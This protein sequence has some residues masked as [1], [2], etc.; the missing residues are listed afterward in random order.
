V[1]WTLEH[2]HVLAGTPWWASI[3]IAAVVFRIVQFYP[4]VL[5]ADNGARMAAITPYTKPIQ[6]KMKAAMA[7]GDKNLAAQTQQE[8]QRIYKKSGIKIWK[9]FTPLLGGLIGFGSW[10]ILRGMSD[11]PVPGLETG[12]LLWFQN[13]AIPDPLFLLPLATSVIMHFVFKVSFSSLSAN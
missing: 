13:L 5:A 8:L 2:I 10:R 12:G 9:S 3:T 1:E 7:S 11:L 4:T 6:E